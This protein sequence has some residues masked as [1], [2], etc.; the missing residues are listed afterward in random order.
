MTARGFPDDR[1]GVCRHASRA[2][3]D[4]SPSLR[5]RH[6]SPM[7][8]KSLLQSRTALQPSE[9]AMKIPLQRSLVLGAVGIGVIGLIYAC[10]P[11]A[12]TGS[13]ATGDAASKVYVPPG[14]YDEF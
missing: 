5:S 8:L 9:P 1:S 11:R 13:L 10:T 7:H 14:S 3:P 12:T 2:N 4:T 6:S